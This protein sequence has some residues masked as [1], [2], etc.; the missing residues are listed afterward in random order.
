MKKTIKLIYVVAF[1]LMAVVLFAA[2]FYNPIHFLFAAISGALCILSL[3]LSV[4]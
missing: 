4:Q 2:G 1:G 3:K